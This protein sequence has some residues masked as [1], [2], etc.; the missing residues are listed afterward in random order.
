MCGPAT[1]KMLLDYFGVKKSEK[2]LA[3]LMKHS[4]K[5]GTD[6]KDAR[7]V[8][9]KFGFKILIKNNSSFAE[10]KKWLDRGV[11]VIVDWFARGRND[12]PYL[13]VAEGHY[14]IV[15]GLDKE[16]I[17]LQDPEIGALCKYKKEDFL[18]VWFDFHGEYISPKKLYTRQI[19]VLYK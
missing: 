17:Y 16:Y 12:Y 5:R 9:K 4:P 11:P 2:E 3:R 1:M 6:E 18:K 10:I 19:I 15:V 7:R 14:A 13:T 8:A